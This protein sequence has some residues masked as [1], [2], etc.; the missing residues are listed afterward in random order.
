MKEERILMA[1]GSGGKA[2]RDLLEELIVPIFDERVPAP[3]EDTSPLPETSPRMVMTTDG[4]VVKPLFFPGGDIGKLAVCGTVND[5]A[6]AGAKPVALS[7][8]LVIEEGFPVEDLEK[9]LRSM[10]STA[11]SVPVS[12]I[13]G[14]TKVVE[15]GR[16][17]GVYISTAGIG[18][19]PEGVQLTPRRIE[20]GDVVLINGPIGNHEAAVLCARENFLLDAPVRSD[21]APLYR[22]MSTLVSRVP[23]IRCARD[24][25][26]GGLAAVLTEIVG[27]SGL[28][29]RLEEE[30][31][32]VEESVRGLCEM[33]GMEPLFMANEGKMVVVV[34]ESRSTDCL[35]AMKS[36][37][38]SEGSSIIGRVHG[39]NARLTLT[40]P[41]GTSRIVTL[42]YGTQLPRIC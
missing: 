30:L 9:I 12:L 39:E 16:G 14:D 34:P 5:L 25:T 33:L 4:Y 11:D 18:I 23:D 41:Y 8:G 20:S 24:A 21:C 37:P 38:G 42:P 1:H 17:D 31:I 28:G 3:M 29:V 36:V 40:T 13:T 6:T 32:P 2:A 10:K 22:L 35:D 26:R 7:V 19:L 15:R 27:S